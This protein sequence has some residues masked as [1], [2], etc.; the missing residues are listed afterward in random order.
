VSNFRVFVALLLTLCFVT[1]VSLAQVTSPPTAYSPEDQR[2]DLI[3]SALEVYSSSDA[4]TAQSAG[5]L[6][7]VVTTGQPEILTRSSSLRSGA[8]DQT[9]SGGGKYLP[10]LFSA[11]MPGLGEIYLGYKWRGAVLVALEVT[12]WA[13]YFYYRNEGLDTRSAYESFA[14]QH[15]GY[16]KWIDDHKD[17]GQGFTLEELEEAGRA[18]A[19]SQDWPGYIPWVSKEEDKQHYYEN[20]GKYDWY[21]SGWRDWDPNF[22]DPGT[23][24][25]YME[26]TPLRD[27]YRTMRKESNDQLDTSNKFIYLSIGTRV[28][29]IVETLILAHRSGGSNDDGQSAGVSSGV[30]RNQLNFRARPLGLTGAEIA[31]E[32]NFK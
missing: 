26:N 9:G 30:S 15:W 8:A 29:S 14:D 4:L 16:Q 28:F 31:L 24:S 6:S 23:D 18:K 1:G 2:L 25:G 10:V 17:G 3:P 32:Y 7:A 22:T 21:I 13:G 12:A 27:E 19:G 11:L 5:E 20:I